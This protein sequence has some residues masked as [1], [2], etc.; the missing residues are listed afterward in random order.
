MIS[1]A[2]ADLRSPPP[3]GLRPSVVPTCA[4]LSDEGDSPFFAETKIGTVPLETVAPAD[5]TALAAVVRAAFERQQAVYPVGGG[6]TSMTAC[7]E[8]NR[9]SNSRWRR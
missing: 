9:A 6:A 4:P 1:P 2:S 5:V 8:I 3:E 7:R